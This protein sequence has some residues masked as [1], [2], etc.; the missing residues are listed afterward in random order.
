MSPNLS[1]YDPSLDIDQILAQ[2]NSSNPHLP[3]PEDLTDADLSQ[4]EDQEG[5]PQPN[6]TTMP[7]NAHHMSPYRESPMGQT[8]GGPTPALPMNIN[9]S[10]AGT[11]QKPALGSKR[12]RLAED[13]NDD[14]DANEWDPHPQGSP[15]P[16]ANGM[17]W[18]LQPNAAAMVY[19]WQSANPGRSPHKRELKALML[20]TRASRSAILRVFQQNGS[21]TLSIPPT[22]ANLPPAHL[23]ARPDPENTCLAK[24]R[25]LLSWDKPQDSEKM[26]SCTKKCGSTFRK[27]GDWI[28]HELIN[29]PQYSW[30]CPLPNC[31]SFFGRK[32]KLRDHLKGVHDKNPEIFDLDSARTCFANQ[33]SKLC[34]FCG[35]NC[36]NWQAWTD[37]VGEHFEDHIDGGPWTMSLWR[38]PWVGEAD[39]S[40]GNDGDDNDDDED[41][42]NDEDQDGPHDSSDDS[43]PGFGGPT[44][45]NSYEGPRRRNGHGGTPSRPGRSGKP[46]LNYQAGKQFSVSFRAMKASQIVP[47]TE[48]VPRTILAQPGGQLSEIRGQGRVFNASTWSLTKDQ[49]FPKPSAGPFLSTEQTNPLIDLVCTGKSQ[50]DAHNAE[51][52][53]YLESQAQALPSS[54]NANDSEDG[55]LGEFFSPSRARCIASRTSETGAAYNRE[56]TSKL[57]NSRSPKQCRERYHQHLKPSHSANS[58][59]ST[60]LHTTSHWASEVQRKSR[61]P[62]SD[63]GRRDALG[64]AHP[65]PSPILIAEQ[66]SSRSDSSLG[67]K[68]SKIAANKKDDPSNVIEFAFGSETGSYLAASYPHVSTLYTPPTEKPTVDIVVVHGMNGPS[69]SAW[70]QSKK[71][72]SDFRP[73]LWASSLLPRGFD[74]PHARVLAYG[75]S[76]ILHARSSMMEFNSANAILQHAS[77]LLDNLAQK[78]QRCAT[79]PIFFVCDAAGGTIAEAAIQRSK[80]GINDSFIQDIF[81]SLEGVFH[82]ESLDAYHRRHVIAKL[83]NSRSTFLWPSTCSYP[84]TDPRERQYASASGLGGAGLHTSLTFDEQGPD[85]GSQK[86]NSIKGQ[87]R[88]PRNAQHLQQTKYYTSLVVL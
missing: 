39:Q 55:S 72:D 31:P 44:R 18:E 21:S 42:E 65:C 49:S 61:K 51:L 82:N 69:F 88:G 86:A 58:S 78:R 33:F 53:P 76:D 68:L 62:S 85:T 13:N 26:Y 30:T 48:S 5:T 24:K 22:N 77:Y 67:S 54:Q 81:Q 35:H 1:Q 7:P 64:E 32:D 36:T 9:P 87:I 2:Q 70:T 59:G 75:Y 38:D 28:R 23:T 41:S 20:V 43:G 17:S 79:R 11:F 56:L 19:L 73:S 6:V 52:A 74:Q 45:G 66:N 83:S 29:C 25:S 47:R 71:I 34:G 63:P 50:R 40:T 4:F 15:T 12:P 84:R 8:Y 57:A 60:N 80:Q 14:Y 10:P 46:G 3:Q 16:S 27:K 37:H